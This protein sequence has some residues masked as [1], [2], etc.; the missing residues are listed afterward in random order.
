[1]IRGGLLKYLGKDKYE[2]ARLSVLTDRVDFYCLEAI[3]TEAI[4]CYCNKPHKGIDLLNATPFAAD[5]ALTLQ[6]CDKIETCRNNNGPKALKTRESKANKLKLFAEK[7]LLLIGSP[8]REDEFLSP[9]TEALMQHTSRLTLG[10]ARQNA[11]IAAKITEQNRVLYE[12][13]RALLRQN[14]ELKGKIGFLVDEAETVKTEREIKEAKKCKRLNAVKQRQ[15]DAISPEEF[16]VILGMVGG[17]PYKGA[18]IRV[19]LLIMYYTGLRVS[20]LLKLTVNH[21]EDLV[22]RGQITLAILKRGPTRHRV[23]LSNRAKRTLEEALPDIGVLNRGKSPNDYFFTAV[24]TKRKAGS[25]IT[26]ELFN[27][28]INSILIQASERLGKFLRS[29]SFRATFIT[30]LLESGA[31]IYQVKDIVGHSSI[32]STSVYQRSFLSQKELK[33]ILSSYDKAHR[34]AYVGRVSKR[35]SQIVSKKLKR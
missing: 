31:S 28:E 33:K 24:P 3:V 30:D 9:E 6:P 17:T 32:A 8:Q 20:N 21:V 18:R 15:R 23:E 25:S 19:A 35:K 16:D 22:V 14:E 5:E 12:Q 27:R 7:E 13:N 11:T 34:E 29:H 2:K 10:L 4:S 26:R 1:L